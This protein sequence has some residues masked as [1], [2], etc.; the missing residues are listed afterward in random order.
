[1]TAGSE[2]GSGKRT[3][4]DTGT[5][6]GPDPYC[7]PCNDAHVVFCTPQNAGTEAKKIDSFIKRHQGHA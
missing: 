2:G 4:G 3:G 5:A 6:P 7:C 1:R